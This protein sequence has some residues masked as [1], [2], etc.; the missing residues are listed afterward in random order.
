MNSL[1]LSSNVIC[2]FRLPFCSMDIHAPILQVL[3][4]VIPATPE[5]KVMC[6]INI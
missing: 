2:L 1:F 6:T 5:Q 3:L 4:N